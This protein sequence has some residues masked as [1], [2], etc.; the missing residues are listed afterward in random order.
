MKLTAPVRNALFW[1]IFLL[2]VGGFIY[3][4]FF[5]YPAQ[6]AQT[7]LYLLLFVPDCPLFS[8]LF[9]LSM[10]LVRFAPRRFD[11]FNFLTFAGCLKYGFWTVFV[12][13]A[14]PEFYYPVGLGALL[15]A[16][17]LILAHM[18]MFFESFLL[19]S[20]VRVKPWHLVP[21]LGFFLLSDYS[22]YVLLTYPAAPTYALPLLFP[23]TVLM[24]IFFT[25]GG[26]LILR[27][28]KRPLVRLL[29]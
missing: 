5:F 19:A 11:L 23:L 15:S 12:L 27:G 4:T 9:A 26:Y 3:G 8:L 10:L 29:A 22:D 1:L 20:F 17:M 16:L 2:N 21:V 25:L 7:P 24:S 18:G 6:L 14:Y 28:A 13:T